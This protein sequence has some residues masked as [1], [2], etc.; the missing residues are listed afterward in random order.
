M[1]D[2]LTAYILT[3]IL[4]VISFFIYK[5]LI[6]PFYLS[7]LCK[8]PGP[9]SE[10]I[11]FGNL[12]TILNSNVGK[13]HLDWKKKYG[14]ILVYH[15]FLNKPLILLTDPKCYPQILTS[16]EFTKPKDLSTDL[17][18]ILGDGILFAE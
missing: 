2:N 18:L 12:L 15:G 7:P 3:I 6:G 17:K 8:I 11:L 4:G 5:S 13:P 14:R 10:S 16:Y 1:I 9:P